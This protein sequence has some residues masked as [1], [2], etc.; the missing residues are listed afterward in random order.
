MKILYVITKA[1]WGGA[2]RY[3][4][5]LA[6][7]AK[8]RGHDV[9]VIAGDPGELIDRL[10][11][12]GIRVIPV[13]ELT[14]NIRITA[15]LK[16]YKRLLEL[17]RTEAPDVLHV[18][19]SKAGGI[20][21]LAGRVARVPTIVFTAHGWA[22]NEKRP[23]WQKPVI[24]ALHYLTTL[25]AHKTICVSDA[26]RRDARLMLG[27]SMKVI[28]HGVSP[29]LLLPAHEAR[30]SLAPALLSHQ[31]IGSIAELH[32][33]KQLDVLVR[34][35]GMIA[36]EFTDTGLVLMGDGEERM[37]LEKLRD[38]LSLQER[39]ILTGHVSQASRYLAA[40][41]IFVLPSRSEALGY[42]VLEAG[43]ATLPVIAS[44][45]G[46]IPEIV[47]NGE[48][49][50]LVRSGSILEL[51]DALRTLLKDQAL[52]ARYGE[53]LKETVHTRFLK[54]QMLDATFALY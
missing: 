27:A 49:G 9:A 40:L 42:A 20:A 18:N 15:E 5:D 25:L 54:D 14:R 31:W 8:E 46:G 52:R 23:L 12:A 19:S 34:A 30:I 7:A 10:L 50:I 37:K 28:H 39:I 36:N 43:L 24:W 38:E 51:A 4:F 22:F 1:N 48:N 47:T 16:T 17:L 26:I 2:Q 6:T 32:P 41:D 3:V 45:V 44:R 11:R 21:S 29:T 33:T 13:E 35:F 53:A